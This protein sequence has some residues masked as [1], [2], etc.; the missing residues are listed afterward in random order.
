M[1]PLGGVA[2]FGFAGPGGFAVG[3]KLELFG[4]AAGL[5]A[6]VGTTF[7]LGSSIAGGSS[8]FLKR[9]VTRWT[10]AFV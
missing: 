5:G 2:L 9:L 10:S 1:T 4:G 7:G 3:S 6:G 8:S